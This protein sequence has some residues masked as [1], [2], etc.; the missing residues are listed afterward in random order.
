LIGPRLTNALWNGG[1]AEAWYEIRYGS[2][3]DKLPGIAKRRYMESALFGLYDNALSTTLDEA[4]SVYRM[5]TKYRDDI[6]KYE[7]T[8]GVNSDGTA[9]SKG[10]FIAEA[11]ADLQ[12]AGMSNIAANELD[13]ALMLAANQLVAEYSEYIVDPV[14]GGDNKINTLNIQVTNPNNKAALVGEDTATKTGSNADLLIGTEGQTDYLYGQDG[15][16]V[17]IGGSGDDVLVGGK[18]NDVLVGGEGNDTYIFR[19]GDGHD[20][21]IDSDRKGRIVIDG[22]ED[23]VVASILFKDATAANTWKS[24]DGKLTISH[25]SPYKLT[26]ADG[27]VIELGDFQD[28]DLGIHLLDTPGATAAATNLIT[29][30]TADDNGTAQG[31]LRGTTANDQIHGLAGDDII[32][33]D[34]GAFNDDQDRLYGDEGQDIVYAGRGNDSLY[35]GADA[36]ILLGVDGDDVLYAEG[37]VTLSDAI[38]AGE[39]PAGTTREFLGGGSGND[40]LVGGDGEAT[41]DLEWREAA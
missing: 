12:A 8:Y 21:I 13:D 16:D 30:T 28:S 37:E 31:V 25:N 35:G 39:G 40:I 4:F 41:N 33:A 17:L 24:A 9:G 32:N 36:D 1:R 3:G 11:N 26:T 14:R 27:D 19:S 23:A 6:F 2:N 5:Y 7:A 10:N 38:V 29:G 15:N 18:G 22:V 34:G 20:R